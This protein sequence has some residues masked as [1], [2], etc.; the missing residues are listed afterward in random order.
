[1]RTP[2]FLLLAACEVDPTGAEPSALSAARDDAKGE[3]SSDESDAEPWIEGHCLGDPCESLWLTVEPQTDDVVWWIDGEPVAKGAGV[4][5]PLPMAPIQI[6][7]STP[8]GDLDAAASAA[9]IE[10]PDV[11]PQPY[12]IIQMVRSC[13]EF[14]VVA[15][16]GCFNGSNR[17]RFDA[18]ALWN[19]YDP[20]GASG[21]VD[22]ALTPPTANLQALGFAYAAW[23]PITNG[24]AR[25]VAFAPPGVPVP[26]T[27]S[28]A[29]VEFRPA[30]ARGTGASMQAV[31]GNG[32][33]THPLQLFTAVC[34]EGGVA[35]LS[36][37]GGQ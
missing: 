32:G 37:G 24:Q 26:Q 25:S 16:G 9:T 30:V 10:D 36:P 23:W 11:G 21:S 1:M 13:D 31:H 12:V 14:R 18:P 19:L 6:V 8:S 5:V 15:V 22:F 28:T 20:N 29:G 34:T 4:V 17:V 7:A 35:S 33:V 2:I 3:V 27:T